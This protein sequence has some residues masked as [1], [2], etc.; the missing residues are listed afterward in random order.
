[1]FVATG[2]ALFFAACASNPAPQGWLPSAE[3]GQKDPY[4]AWV[5][6]SYADTSVEGVLRAGDLV[7][8]PV[9]TEE[10]ELIA[11]DHDTLF[12]LVESLL[13]AVP[14]DRIIDARTCAYDA[15]YGGLAAWNLLGTL[16]TLSNGYFAGL[17]LPLWLIVG[18]MS[19]AAQSHAPFE[20]YDPRS[21]QLDESWM[22]LGHYARFPQGLPPALDRTSLRTKPF[23][24]PTKRSRPRTG[25]AW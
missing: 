2:F 25:P 19:V 21:F 20:R 11:L 23:S 24:M 1:V 7:H 22:Q 9:R 15:N 5:V 14:H 17:T 16:S 8:A 4:G 12:F 3:E 10:G 18:S 13:V 6:V